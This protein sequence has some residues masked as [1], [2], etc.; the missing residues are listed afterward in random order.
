MHGTFPFCLKIL[1]QGIIPLNI[2][3]RVSKLKNP[4]EKNCIDKYVEA[5]Y[6]KHQKGD[7]SLCFLIGKTKEKA[8]L[9]MIT[10]NA[11]KVFE[12]KL[13][14]YKVFEQCMQIRI[15][16]S[17]FTKDGCVVYAKDKDMRIRGRLNYGRLT[18][19][20]YSSEKYKSGFSIL[21]RSIISLD[22]NVTGTFEINGEK[23]D[24]N[25]AKGYIEHSNDR[26]KDMKFWCQ[27]NSFENKTGIMICAKRIFLLKNSFDAV[28]AS[29]FYHGKEYRFASYFGARVS[30][31][32]DKGIVINQG[33]YRLEADFENASDY[34]D[35]AETDYG[36]KIIVG[37]HIHFKMFIDG[38]PFFNIHSNSGS[39][40]YTPPVPIMEY[41][42]PIEA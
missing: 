12:Y 15:G 34:F 23:L 14:E 8:F 32:D 30:E 40:E 16:D 24:I 19:S 1:F 13:R 31:C 41:A 38:V 10:N 5:W 27:C 17:I 25:G 9:Q 6:F 3:Q 37:M 35:Y 4:D 26:G 18:C 39:V 22:H 29:V 2:K 42:E 20:K 21:G 11:C 36:R 28:E 7:Q 33:R